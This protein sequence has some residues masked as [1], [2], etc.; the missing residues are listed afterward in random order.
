MVL[1]QDFPRNSRFALKWNKKV[2]LTINHLH[3]SDLDSKMILFTNA[4]FNENKIFSPIICSKF[5]VVTTCE[6]IICYK[7]ILR[8]FLQSSNIYKLSENYTQ[9]PKFDVLFLALARPCTILP[10]IREVT[11][12][13]TYNFRIKSEMYKKSI[14]RS[15]MG[16]KS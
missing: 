12:V 1:E 10:A 16:Q 4:Y 6:F 15:L 7:I 3:I 5:N 13:K 2:F 14:S 11:L 8:F 9:I